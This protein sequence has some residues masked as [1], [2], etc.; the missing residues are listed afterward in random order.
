M[1]KKL[2][3]LVASHSEWSGR[4]VSRKKKSRHL[5]STRSHDNLDFELTCKIFFCCTLTRVTRLDLVGVFS[6]SCFISYLWVLFYLGSTIKRMRS[7]LLGSDD[8][9]GREFFFSSFI[10]PTNNR[11]RYYVSDRQHL[12]PPL[13]R[14][15]A[16]TST[17]IHPNKST[18]K[19]PR[20]VD[21]SLGP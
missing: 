19:G 4:K 20:D 13:P 12:H 2:P 6:P 3:L 11:Y 7:I 9:N 15:T 8:K 21:T 10:Y 17:A 14:R 16:T 18:K 5:S 1:W